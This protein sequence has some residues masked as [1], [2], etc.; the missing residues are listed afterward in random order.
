MRLFSVAVVLLSLLCVSADKP[1]KK[2]ES[3]SGTWNTV[4]RRLNGTMTCDITHRE[5]DKWKGRFHGEWQGQRFSYNVEWSGPPEKL[6]GKARIDGA[7]YEWKGEIKDD[8]FKGEFTGSR[9][10]GHFNLKKR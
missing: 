7:S 4:N 2:Q 8:V 10:N 6:V 1:A 9:Y 3:Y 5:G